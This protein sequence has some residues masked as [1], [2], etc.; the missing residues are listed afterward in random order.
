M[1]GGVEMT[2]PIVAAIP[3]TIEL[4]INLIKLSKN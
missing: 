4:K 2:Y 3:R 1:A